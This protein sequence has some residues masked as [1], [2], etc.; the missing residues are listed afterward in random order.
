MKIEG[1][2]YDDRWKDKSNYP[3]VNVLWESPSHFLAE[4]EHIDE[5]VLIVRRLSQGSDFDVLNEN[6]FSYLFHQTN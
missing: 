4:F 3:L 6:Y 5:P 2:L 1:Y